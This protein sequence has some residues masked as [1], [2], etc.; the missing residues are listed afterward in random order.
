MWCHVLGE[1]QWGAYDVFV[2][3][4]DVVTLRIRWIVV[5]G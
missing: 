5:K 4:V 2:E 1:G 3:E